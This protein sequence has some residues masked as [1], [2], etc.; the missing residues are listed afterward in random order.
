[1]EGWGTWGT[2]GC[3]QWG[4]G[5]GENH[6]SKSGLQVAPNNQNA[7]WTLKQQAMLQIVRTQLMVIFGRITACFGKLGGPS[8]FRG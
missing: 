4:G 3:G 5:K 2:E 6:V 7:M 8:A 1:M